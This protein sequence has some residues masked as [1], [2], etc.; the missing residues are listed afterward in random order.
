MSCDLVTEIQKK[1]SHWLVHWSRW[2]YHNGFE[3]WTGKGTAFQGWHYYYYADTM[4]LLVNWKITVAG[5]HAM[6]VECSSV[7]MSLQ[8]RLKSVNRRQVVSQVRR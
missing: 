7:E 1:L 5:S 4:A 2:L 6:S 8:V 3:K